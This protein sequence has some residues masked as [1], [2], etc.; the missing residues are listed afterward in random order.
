MTVYLNRERYLLT[1]SGYNVFTELLTPVCVSE[2]VMCQ[3]NV[4]RMGEIRV[5]C[6]Y[7]LPFLR[8]YRCLHVCKPSLCFLTVHHDLSTI[9]GI[10]LHPIECEKEGKKHVK[11]SFQCFT[12]R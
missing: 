11:I 5:L 6:N 1:V 10:N 4:N 2:H 7:G 12:F 3:P 8:K 9:I